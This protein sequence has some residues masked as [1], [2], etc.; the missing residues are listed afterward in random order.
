MTSEQC[1]SPHEDLLPNPDVRGSI[2]TAEGQ[3][4]TDIKWSFIRAEAKG[5][6]QLL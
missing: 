6:T 4:I 5:R 3:L 1:G 2:C